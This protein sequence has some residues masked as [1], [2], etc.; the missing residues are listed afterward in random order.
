MFTRTFSEP[1]FGTSLPDLLPCVRLCS[2]GVVR[3]LGDRAAE[4][5][6]HRVTVELGGRKQAV[7]KLR[8]KYET[9]VKVSGVRQDEGNGE[10]KS[11]AF[12]LIAAAQKRE[13]LQREGDELDQLI[14]KA[15]KEI[16]ALDYTLKHL[17]DRN[18]VTRAAHQRADM[19]GPEAEKLRSL[20][21]QAKLAQV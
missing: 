12:Y 15:S 5:E 20:E 11:Q 21:E 17:N 4:E 19:A 6:R 10:P 3:L 18:G 14:Q 8:D 9:L 1:N 2:R 16:K 7:E 13:E